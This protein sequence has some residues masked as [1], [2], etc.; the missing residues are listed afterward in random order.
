MRA[1]AQ[2]PFQTRGFLRPHGE[3]KDHGKTNRN[4]EKTHHP[5]FSPPKDFPA[6]NRSYSAEGGMSYS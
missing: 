4:N 5:H 3:A 2:Q 6:A 1:D